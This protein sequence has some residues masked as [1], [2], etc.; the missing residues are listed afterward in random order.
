M[1]D[2]VSGP[3]TPIEDKNSEMF[4]V[5]LLKEKGY[6]YDVELSTKYMAV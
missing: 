6:A 1:I 3:R 2:E 4:G 5:N